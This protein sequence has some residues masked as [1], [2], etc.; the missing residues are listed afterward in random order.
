MDFSCGF[1]A[2][3]KKTKKKVIKK[4]VRPAKKK[5]IKKSVKRKSGSAKKQ[6]FLEKFKSAFAKVFSSKKLSKKKDNPIVKSILSGNGN[7]TMNFSIKKR[8]NLLI[9]NLVLF[10][11][12]FILSLII[13][14][15]SNNE[16]YKNLFFILLIIFGCIGLALLIALLIFIFLKVMKK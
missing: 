1:M 15:V 2:I 14:N 3:K 11:V 6:N 16:V 8:M 9:Y 5:V 13:Y 7:S 10:A 4:K 12:L